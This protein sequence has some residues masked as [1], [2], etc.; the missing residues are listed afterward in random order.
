MK[1]RSNMSTITTSAKPSTRSQPMKS[2]RCYAWV[3]T[4][5]CVLL[6]LLIT[7]LGH[8]F[9][10]AQKAHVAQFAEA[11]V[12]RS[13]VDSRSVSVVVIDGDTERIV[14]YNQSA[15]QL[16]GYSLEEVMH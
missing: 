8:L 12:W 1:G 10:K 13:I 11:E 14:G 9:N 2:E 3:V 4:A 15:R 5:V 16:L 7:F 6:C